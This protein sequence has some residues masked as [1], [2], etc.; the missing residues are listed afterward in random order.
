MSTNYRVTTPKEFFSV[1][2]SKPNENS[3]LDQLSDALKT[4]LQTV[5]NYVK[6]IDVKSPGKD[7][8]RGKDDK[9]GNSEGEHKNDIAADTKFTNT[10]DTNNNEQSHTT[11]TTFNS[12]S[13]KEMLR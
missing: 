7:G 9:V 2:N 13:K 1:P 10:K 8:L 12:V 11:S 6:N 5:W 4:S 3:F